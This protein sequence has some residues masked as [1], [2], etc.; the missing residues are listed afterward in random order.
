MFK[1]AIVFRIETWNPPAP[2]ELE[3]RLAAGRFAPCSATQALS[4]GWVAPRGDRQA[5]LIESVGGQLILELCVEKKAVPTSA[6][7]DLLEQ[8]LDKVE[9][10]TGR[11]PRGKRSRELKD[12]IVQELLPRAFPKRSHAHVWIDPEA[13]R[14]VVGAT[15]AA[16]VDLIGTALTELFAPG[17][18]L[19]PAQTQR[20]PAVA[21]AEWLSTREAP[22]GFSIDREC[23]LKQPDSEKA[24]VRYARH[25]L[26]IDEVAGHIQQGKVPTQL[27]MTWDSR[28]SFVLTESLAIKKIKL[29]DVALEGS[30]DDGGFEAD[31]A[32][33]TGEL[34]RLL[35]ELIDALGGEPA[36]A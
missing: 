4:C 24:S 30:D 27:A 12:E 29:L 20:S 1:N 34:G 25:T 7:K 31:V 26:D 23:E 15:G 28:V 16:M 8:R 9:A 32:L 18:V 21:M 10:E 22:A 6:V 13:G 19:S 35:P 14:V 11:R 5:P 33:A 2:A 17:T 36:P 3:A